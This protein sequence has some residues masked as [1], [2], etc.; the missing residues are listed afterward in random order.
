[1]LGA[2]FQ[3]IR[4][5]WSNYLYS[6]KVL[7]LPISSRRRWVENFLIWSEAVHCYESP[8]CSGQCLLPKLSAAW[9]RQLVAAN[10]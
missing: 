2:A 3:L 1:M 5:Y 9:P 10:C 6:Q 8:L 7:M 4:L